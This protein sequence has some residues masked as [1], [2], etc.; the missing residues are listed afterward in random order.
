M[1]GLVAV[2]LFIRHIVRTDARAVV[3]EVVRNTRDLACAL[4][5]EARDNLERDAK[6]YSAFYRHVDV[7]KHLGN[8]DFMTT[9]REGGY[10]IVHLFCEVDSSGNLV[11]GEGVRVDGGALLEAC[12]GPT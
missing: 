8:A 7:L 5:E 11:D 6:I 1:I 9:V 10:D 12:R 2:A 3:S 4:N